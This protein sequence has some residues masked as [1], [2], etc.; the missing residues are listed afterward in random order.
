MVIFKHHKSRKDAIWVSE[1]RQSPDAVE[2]KE[3]NDLLPLIGYFSQVNIDP[4]FI[5]EGMRT[6][7]TYLTAFPKKRP[8]V[9]YV[10]VFESAFTKE[11]N[12]LNKIRLP[13]ATNTSKQ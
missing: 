8:D 6:F 5:E 9:Y 10:W 12:E 4:W 11:E 13:N 7:N 1:E 2:I 3:P